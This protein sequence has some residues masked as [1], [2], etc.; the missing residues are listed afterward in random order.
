MTPI[1]LANEADVEAILAIANRAAEST[2]ANFA[3]APERLD[4]WL[5]THRA[6]RATHPWL[7]ARDRDRVVGFAKAS[8]HRAR[9]AYAWT[10]EVSVYVEPAAHRRGLGRALY[11]LLIP[12]LRAQGYVTLL[13]G[14]ALPNDASVALHERAGFRAC[15]AYH[16][17]GFKRGHWI[18]VGYWEQ[19]L[20]LDHVPP[21]E[22]WSVERVLPKVRA[23]L[24][25]ELAIE[26]VGLD[27]PG[28]MDLIGEL[29]AELDILYPEPGANFFRLDPDEV[30]GDRGAFLVARLDGEA[31]GCGA[32]RMMK[33]ERAAELKRMYVPARWR[34]LG[35]S[36]AVL[37]ALER[38]AKALGATRALLET[39]ARQVAA[40]G[41]YERAGYARVTPFGEY[42][43]AEH[44][45]C[46][47]KEL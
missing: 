12:L 33:A 16:R 39:G 21:G 13:A 34:G 8:V 31:V 46:M 17:V 9:G 40:V 42:A 44:S 28:V 32:I 14:I 24:A 23:G 4:D 30:T 3:T 27:A 37:G 25:G 20:A 5:A 36:K 38:Q 35:V 47:G 29:N 1:E 11:G 15:G 18:D 43:E 26:R 45:L 2:D 6:T 41:L 19:H 10:A 7:V 22:L